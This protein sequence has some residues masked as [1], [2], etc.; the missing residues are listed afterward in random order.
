MG[1][2]AL[3]ISP[4]IWLSQGSRTDQCGNIITRY[5]TLARTVNDVIPE[6]SKVF[7]YG[8]EA[9]MLM[10]YLPNREILPQRVNSDFGIRDVNDQD[11]LLALGLYNQDIVSEWTQ[12]ADYLFVSE[13]EFQRYPELL[14]WL[15]ENRYSEPV[16][17]MPT[18]RDVKET[19]LHL[20]KKP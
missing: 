3:F 7:W 5:E 10:L 17:L 2:F 18:C 9:A 1:V 16:S 15:T 19:T 20:Y 8:N 13:A 14:L 11:A 12:N 6:Q 4:T